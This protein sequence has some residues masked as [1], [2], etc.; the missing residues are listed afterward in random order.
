ML[1][2]LV[3]SERRTR[4]HPAHVRAKRRCCAGRCCRGRFRIRGAEEGVRAGPLPSDEN[5]ARGVPRCSA[6]GPRS[7]MRGLPRG[8]AHRVAE[9]RT[10]E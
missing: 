5:A 8:V 3:R 7:I 2:G 1:D 6:G 10:A 4:V 9:G